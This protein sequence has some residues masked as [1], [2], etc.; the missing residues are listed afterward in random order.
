MTASNSSTAC[1]SHFN[2][3]TRAVDSVLH[4]AHCLSLDSSSQPCI[5]VLMLI[6]N[7]IFV[8]RYRAC[9]KQVPLPYRPVN[10]RLTWET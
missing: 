4:T 2:V 7:D 10:T 6:D 1:A 9:K 8:L 3:V 5:A